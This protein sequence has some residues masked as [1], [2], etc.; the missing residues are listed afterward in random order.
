MKRR[1]SYFTA[2]QVAIVLAFS[3]LVGVMAWKELRPAPITFES[4]AVHGVTPTE[5]KVT[6]SVRRTPNDCT[7]GLQADMR[8]GGVVT[9]LPP[10]VRLEANGATE[11]AL[12][13]PDLSPGAYEVQVRELFFC[14]GLRVAQTPWLALTVP[15]PEK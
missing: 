11:Y 3:A 15:V 12:A 5:A 14:P 9:R 4:V 2:M 8:Q 7:T 6:A 13:L 10:P 1:L